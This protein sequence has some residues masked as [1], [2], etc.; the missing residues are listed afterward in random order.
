MEWDENRSQSGNKKKIEINNYSI[1]ILSMIMKK[2]K[3]FISLLYL[4]QQNIV[5]I[6]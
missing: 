6:E 3:Y 1:I 5:E 2:N 4:V